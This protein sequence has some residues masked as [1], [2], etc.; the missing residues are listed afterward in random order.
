[1][2]ALR[3]GCAHTRVCMWGCVR[4]FFFFEFLLFFFEFLIFYGCGLCVLVSSLCL[5]KCVCV[6]VC[7]RSYVCECVRACVS[8]HVCIQFAVYLK[9]FVWACHVVDLIRTLFQWQAQAMFERGELERGPGERP[10]LD[11]AIMARLSRRPV[12]T[13]FALPAPGDAST[14]QQLE[15]DRAEERAATREALHTASVYAD[16]DEACRNVDL[17]DGTGTSIQDIYCNVAD[18]HALHLSSC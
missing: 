14:T 11:Q 9:D 1:M 4:L 16:V 6:C 15:A 18:P 12:P 17:E 5:C 2:C 8:M 13:Q 10:T 7:V 3:A